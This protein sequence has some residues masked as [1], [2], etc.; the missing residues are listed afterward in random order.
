MAAAPNSRSRSVRSTGRGYGIRDRH[1]RVSARARA[2]AWAGT[3]LS[4]LLLLGASVG[5]LG[6]QPTP[7]GTRIVHAAQVIYQTA[8]GQVDTVTSEATVMLVGQIGGIDL[9]PPGVSATDPGATVTFAHR[10]RNA[11]NGVDSFT[12]T[13]TSRSGWP[14]RLYRDANGNGVVDGTD[15]PVTGPIMLDAGLSAWLLVAADV[16]GNPALRGRTDTLVVTGASLFDPA[17]SDRLINQTQ[18]RTSGI[19]VALEKSVDRA[20]AT[21]GEILTYTVRF[22]AEGA[23]RATNVRLADPIPLGTTYVPGTMRL[24]GATLSDG[25][26]NDAGL[27]DVPNN[28]VVVVLA[29]LA[30]G[31]SGAISFQVR[32]GR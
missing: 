1:T 27:F 21:I 18:I 9:E 10:L 2:S 7:A 26:D 8:N 15:P 4:A 19:A 14:V 30:G 13:A 28:R 6:A 23:N 31:E 11:G 5:S 22:T 24:N 25:A 17:I 16:P 3:C 12:V 32:V 20:S 29:S